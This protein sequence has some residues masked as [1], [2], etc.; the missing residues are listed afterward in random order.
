V[1]G[2]CWGSEMFTTI[3]TQGEPMRRENRK[4]TNIIITTTTTA[5]RLRHGR[6][7][8]VPSS[9]VFF[10]RPARAVFSLS[11]P[12]VSIFAYYPVTV[13]LLEVV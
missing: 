5:Q 1:V 4:A 9:L 10:R 13:T 2:S 12:A 11:V 8:F 7:P 3:R 6:P